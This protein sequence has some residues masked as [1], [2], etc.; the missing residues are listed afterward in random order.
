MSECEHCDHGDCHP[1]I[2]HDGKSVSVPSECPRFEGRVV[3]L[4]EY[5][6]LRQEAIQWNLCIWR[7]ERLHPWNDQLR[8]EGWYRL[9]SPISATRQIALRLVELGALEGHRDFT[10]IFRE[11]PWAA[12]SAV[13]TPPEQPA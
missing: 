13:N 8:E 11:I 4:G 12:T 1:C 9:A 2:D 7:A 6:R 10:E 3:P 5:H